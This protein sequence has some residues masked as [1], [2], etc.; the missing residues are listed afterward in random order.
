[1]LTTLKALRFSNSDT[2]WITGIVELWHAMGREMQVAIMAPDGPNDATLRRWA[3]RTGRTRLAALLRIADAFWWAEREA[4]KPAPT[5]VRME[6]V[7]RRAV[8]I[9]YHD[10]V[11]LADL[12]VNGEDLL[13]LGIRGKQ[14]GE[15][16]RML[17]STVIEDPSRNRRDE[18]LQLAAP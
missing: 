18:L 9:A 17:L 3:G 13:A 14:L 1:V 4:G 12:A 15:V 10:P 2:A 11:E 7:Y 8:R 6:S 5:R 16:L